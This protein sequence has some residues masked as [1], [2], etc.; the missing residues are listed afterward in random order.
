MKKEADWRGA[1]LAP[2]SLTLGIEAGRG[3]VSTSCFSLN[4]WL[5]VSKAVSRCC[6][7][8]ADDREGLKSRSN[9]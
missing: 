6:Q 3:V 9:V 2:S 8:S 4:L 7:L 1:E 5:T